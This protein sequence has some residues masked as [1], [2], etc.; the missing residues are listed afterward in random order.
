MEHLWAPIN[1]DYR[2]ILSKGEKNINT[3]KKEEILL[4]FKELMPY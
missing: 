1:S 3:I 4:K 2:L